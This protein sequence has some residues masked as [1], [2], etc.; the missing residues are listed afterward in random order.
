MTLDE[1]IVITSQRL[2]QSL[3]SEQDAERQFHETGSAWLKSF[4]GPEE[5]RCHA[6]HSKNIAAYD[7]ARKAKVKAD[8]EHQ[9]LLKAQALLAELSV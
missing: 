4:N 6:A 7:A 5:K 1:C 3:Q 8:G 9:L 2:A